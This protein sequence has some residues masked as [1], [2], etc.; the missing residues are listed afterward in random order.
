MFIGMMAT[1]FIAFF[2]KIASNENLV[3]PQQN[4]LPKIKVAHFNLSSFNKEQVKIDELFF[5]DKC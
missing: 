4:L 1:A 2:L 3:L 5:E